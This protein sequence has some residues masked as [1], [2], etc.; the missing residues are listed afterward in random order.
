MKESGGVE[1]QSTVRKGKKKRGSRTNTDEKEPLLPADYDFD[2]V[3]PI[4]VKDDWAPRIDELEYRLQDLRS[5][6]Q[7]PW[8]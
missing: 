7:L 4:E 6:Y 2:S 3:R 5:R 8:D 1:A